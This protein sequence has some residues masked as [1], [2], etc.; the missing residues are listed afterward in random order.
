MTAFEAVGR[1]LKRRTTDETCR[2]EKGWINGR[3]GISEG[4]YRHGMSIDR[5]VLDRFEKPTLTMLSLRVSP[6]PQNRL[7]LAHGLSDGIDAALYKLRRRLVE[8]T[9][10]PL[11]DDEWHYVVVIAGTSERATPHAHILVYTDSDVERDRFA[12]AVKWFVRKCPYAPDD[13]RGNPTDRGT[14]RIHGNDDD[15]IPR[16]DDE[17][18]NLRGGV[19]GRNSQAATYALKQLPHLGPVANMARDD[20]LHSSTLDAFG[21][22]A[23]RSS[24]SRDSVSDK[25]Q[26]IGESDSDNP[27]RNEKNSPPEPATPRLER[28]F[29]EAYCTEVGN[30]SPSVILDNIGQNDDVFEESPDVVQIVAIVQGRLES[31]TG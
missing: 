19:T 22:S 20:L 2:S 5:Q 4:Q 7:T 8:D 29:I 17:K 16:V 9:D 3:R 10:A 13:M 11:S 30:P 6:Q 21:G 18:C 15:T 24:L 23:L 14:I 31:A 28:E 1:Y 27:C 26:P 12:D 25:Y